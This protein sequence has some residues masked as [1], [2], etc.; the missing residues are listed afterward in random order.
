MAKRKALTGSA[1]KGL[2]VPAPKERGGRER[3]KKGIATEGKGR[4]ERK[5]KQPSIDF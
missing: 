1:V 5:Y 4:E 3:Y 2:R